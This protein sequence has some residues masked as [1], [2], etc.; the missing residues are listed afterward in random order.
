MI[1]VIHPIHE[2]LGDFISV[3]SPH[4]TSLH[5]I[6]PTT[7]ILNHSLLQPFTSSTIHFFNH[8]LP[9]P[10]V[11]LIFYFLNLLPSQPL[12]SSTFYLLNHPFPPSSTSAASYLPIA[13]FLH[14]HTTYLHLLHVD[15]PSQL[16][17][18]SEAFLGELLYLLN[19]SSFLP[20]DPAF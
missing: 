17:Q 4:P 5:S 10:P 20:L 11:F 3:L 18:W 15:K 7:H 9:H 13:I 19:S 14:R 2:L 8:S 16:V 6:S 1:F 12:S